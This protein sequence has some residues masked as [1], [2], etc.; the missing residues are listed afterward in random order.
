MA[1]TAAIPLPIRPT[2]PHSSPTT[3]TYTSI[4]TTSALGAR[5]LG[6]NDGILLMDSATLGCLQS[7]QLGVIFY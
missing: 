1:T 2:T 5:T 3:G 7:I 4:T 6:G